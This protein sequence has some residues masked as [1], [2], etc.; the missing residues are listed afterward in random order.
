[1]L[2]SDQVFYSSVMVEYI[3]REGNDLAFTQWHHELTRLAQGYVGFVRMDLGPPLPCTD[4]VVKWYSIVHFDS[5][6]HLNRWLTSGDRQ[7]QIAAGRPL[8]RAYRFKSFT[9]GLEGWFSHQAGNTEQSGLGPPAWKQV[10]AVVLGL[11]PTVMLQSF[12]FSHWGVMQSWSPAS[13]M[14]VNNLI[15]SAI[16]TWGVMPV[17]SRGLAF[18]LRPAYRLPRQRVDWLGAAMVCIAFGLL[19]F[20]FDYLHQRV[21]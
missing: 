11:Y 12:I 10:L 21:R 4:G 14:L 5:P 17:L 3:V 7:T 19:V 15:T 2:Q 18:W 8:M 16:L 1:M 13:A 20:V 6:R 9:T